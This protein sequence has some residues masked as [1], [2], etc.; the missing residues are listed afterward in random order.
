M[1]GD[2]KELYMSAMHAESANDLILTIT[3]SRLQAPH[4]CGRHHPRELVS[5][6]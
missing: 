4:R 5:P 1:A 2:T 6:G 3:A